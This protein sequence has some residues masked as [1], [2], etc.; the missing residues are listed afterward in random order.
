MS[1]HSA[2]HFRNTSL[3]ALRNNRSPEKAGLRRRQALVH[4]V[5]YGRRYPGA[6]Y[7]IISIA[8][9]SNLNQHGADSESFADCEVLLAECGTVQLRLPDEFGRVASHLLAVQHVEHA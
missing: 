4:S 1:P 8:S 3:I 7:R 6:N 2:M 9:R 5:G